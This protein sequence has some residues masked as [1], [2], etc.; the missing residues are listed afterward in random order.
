[1]S[2]DRDYHVECYHCEVGPLPRPPKPA[3]EVPEKSILGSL[4]HEMV[5]K[6]RAR[7]CPPELMEEMG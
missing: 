3:V 7:G 2:M 1:M 6:I 5:N 4:G